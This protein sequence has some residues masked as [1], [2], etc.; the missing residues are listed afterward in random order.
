[1]YKG[2]KRRKTSGKQGKG[3]IKEGDTE[4]C[5]MVGVN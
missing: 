4:E 2:K 3:F 5:Y 1:M